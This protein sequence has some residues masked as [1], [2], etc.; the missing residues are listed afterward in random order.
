MYIF[1]QKIII[2]E[3]Y[4]CH[5]KASKDLVKPIQFVKAST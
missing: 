5:S 1:F 4:E 3:I 2:T